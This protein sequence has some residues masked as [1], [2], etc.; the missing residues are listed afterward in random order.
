MPH[1]GGVSALPPMAAARWGVDGE[2]SGQLA[3]S[4]VVA[5]GT[6]ASV[7]VRN[8]KVSINSVSTSR[9]SITTNP[10]V[11]NRCSGILTPERHCLILHDGR[12]QSGLELRNQQMP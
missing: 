6:E 5:D 4:A 8:D 12:R 9:R 11:A 10:V 2:T 7:V 1:F 3:G